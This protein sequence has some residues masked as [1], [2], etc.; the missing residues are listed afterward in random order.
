MCGISGLFSFSREAP[1]ERELVERMTARLV[2]RGPDG[3]GLRAGSGYAL[4]HRRLAI[5]D[6]A[7]GLQPMATPDERLWVTFNGEIY[8]YLDLRRELEGQGVVFRTRSDTEVLLHGYRAWGAQLASKLRGMFAFVIVDEERHELYAARD[9]LGK[10]P[11]YWCEQGEGVAFASELKAL[12][13]L[14]RTWR[15]RADAIAQF[16]ALRYVPDPMTVYEGVQKLPAAHYMTVRDGKVST[17]RYWQLTFAPDARSESEHREEILACLD[18]AV[19]ARLMGEVPLAPF[20]SGGVDSYAVVDSMTRT[21]GR[22]VDACTIG[23]STPEFDERAGARASAAACGANLREE[24]LD[25]DALLDLDWFAETYD[26]PFSDSSAI[27]TYH[28]SRLARRHVTVAL[29][30]DGGDEGFGGYRRYVFDAR[31]HQLRSRLPRA[32]WRALGAAYP[33][34]DWLPRYLR[35]KRTLQNLARDPAEAYARSVSAHLPE[36][37]LAVLRRDHHADAGDPHAAVLQAYRAADGDDPLHRAVATDLE[38]W[39]PGDILVK[40]D[41]ASMAVSLEV[42]APFLDHR[43]LEAAATIPAAWHFTGGR[44]K[45]FLRDTLAGR[46]DQAALRRTKQGFSVPLREWC[47]GSIGDA[48]EAVL[49]EEKLR[50]WLDTEV[51]ASLLQRH[52]QG[53]GDH[54]EMLWAVL[55]LARFLERWAS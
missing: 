21:L 54:S 10:K 41:R 25:V 2:H 24:V 18:D 50:Q 45:A 38:T 39:L 20:L 16:L 6:L 52:R 42:R 23:F 33:K 35:A 40:A 49:G 27:P 34:A 51:L 32:A 12:R 4:G 26:E 46:L 30:G 11:F 44:T 15:L 14:P 22:P 48:V 17:T 19:S 8:N 43:L 55:V 31:E 29:S 9:R 7:G 5:V 53:V 3:D 1:A 37:V 36:E 28:V 13:E 47:Q